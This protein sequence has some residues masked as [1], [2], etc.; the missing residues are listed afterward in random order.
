M[1][2]ASLILGNIL[3]LSLSILPAQPPTWLC[4]APGRKEFPTEGALVLR[5]QVDITLLPD[6]RR[7]KRVFLAVKVLRLPPVERSGIFD[8]RIHF[9]PTR[10]DLKI[11]QA[12]TWL[13]SGKAVDTAGNGKNI[14]FP[15]ALN[16]CP[17]FARFRDMVVTHVGV[18]EGCTVV[19]EYE[20]TETKRGAWPFEGLEEAQFPFPLLRQEFTLEAPKGTPLQAVLLAPSQRRGEKTE[21]VSKDRIRI[22]F[23]REG[24]IPRAAR[25]ADVFVYG[26]KPWKTLGQR[27]RAGLARLGPL[28]AEFLESLKKKLAHPGSFLERADRA[29]RL[30]RDGLREVHWPP[31][32]LDWTVRPAGRIWETTYATP[33]EEA[34]FLAGA[35]RAAGLKDAQVVPITHLPRLEVPCLEGTD[36]FWVAA[37]SPRGRPIWIRAGGTPG[38]PPPARLTGAASLVGP[39]IPMDAWGSRSFSKVAGHLVLSPG[40]KLSGNL[41]IMLQGT[42]FNGVEAALKGLKP[43]A[44]RLAALFAGGR[45]AGLTVLKLEESRALFRMALEGGKVSPDGAGLLP[46]VLPL[47]PGSPPLVL[48][49]LGLPENPS[50]TVLPGGP[51]ESILDLEVTLPE[52]F[53]IWALPGEEKVH[54]PPLGSRERRVKVFGRKVAVFRRL[55]VKAGRVPPARW[56][57]L[58]ALLAPLRNE[59]ARTLLAAPAGDPGR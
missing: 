17:D 54:Q 50:S 45:P 25:P 41:E 59:S 1:K 5:H 43:Q 44:E 58:R 21:E 35:L 34:A 19:L 57:A 27:L 40:G 33:L 49:D 22:R 18:E 6:G 13:P 36:D 39:R 16:L 20:S 47:L 51:W 12:R 23:L 8:P 11:L 38:D 31:R 26:T 30:V 37:T 10:Q 48:H 15:D 29:A 3:L 9:D 53:R 56:E 42:A 24:V 55:Q 46:L 32:L 14:V 4:Q 52:G 2:P 28:P 7:K